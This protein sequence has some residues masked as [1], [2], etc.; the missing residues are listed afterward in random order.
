MLVWLVVGW[1]GKKWDTYS[2]C[3]TKETAKMAIK[4]FKSNDYWRNIEFQATLNAV[5]TSEHFN[6]FID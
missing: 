3:D 6:Q 5:L 4:H 2:V 1:D